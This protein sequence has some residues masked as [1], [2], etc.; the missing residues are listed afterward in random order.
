MQPSDVPEQEEDAQRRNYEQQEMADYIKR[1]IAALGK[2]LRMNGV[3]TG[4][5]QIAPLMSRVPPID[6][7][8]RSNG[9]LSIAST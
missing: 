3:E 6:F 9:D 2:D 7:E 5:D 4:A 1:I 8:I